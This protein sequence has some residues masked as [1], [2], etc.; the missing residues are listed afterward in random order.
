MLDRVAW[1][2]ANRV[3][4]AEFSGSLGL[5]DFMQVHE[6]LTRLI[7]PEHPYPFYVI[8]HTSARIGIDWRLSDLAHVRDIG[9]QHPRLRRVVVVDANPHPLASV[10]G[11]MAVHF[12]GFSLQITRSQDEA[13]AHLCQIDPTLR[14]TMAR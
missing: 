2:V 12:H 6:S 9:Y 5:G 7:P 14:A 4:M 3:V 13:L 8:Y 10:V 1:L 11:R